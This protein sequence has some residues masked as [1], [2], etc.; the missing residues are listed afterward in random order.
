MLTK[1]AML[2]LRRRSPVVTDFTVTRYF[3][4]SVPQNQRSEACALLRRVLAAR[5][6]CAQ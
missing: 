2:M 6:T 3:L 5:S 4:R 1:L